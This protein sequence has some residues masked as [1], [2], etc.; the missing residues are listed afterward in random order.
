MPANLSWKEIGLPFSTSREVQI[1]Q[2]ADGWLVPVASAWGE[3]TRRR[4]ELR[5]VFGAGE[6][7]L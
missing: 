7:L 3:D 2:E 1:F 6:N 4:G 5:L